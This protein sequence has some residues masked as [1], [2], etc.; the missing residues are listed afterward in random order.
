MLFLE[1]YLLLTLSL[2]ILLSTLIIPET[3]ES[4]KH[5][6]MKKTQYAIKK[7][8]WSRDQKNL[9]LQ[10]YYLGVATIESGIEF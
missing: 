9:A 10:S 1:L 3:F 7:Q 4:L 5:V 6:L 8:E 2:A